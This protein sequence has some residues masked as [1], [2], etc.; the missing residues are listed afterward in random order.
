MTIQMYK[1]ESLNISLISDFIGFP[2]KV[3]AKGKKVM[4]FNIQSDEIRIQ[5]VLLN[6]QSNALKFTP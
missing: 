1:S 5:Q 4:N 6:L 3:D 2:Y